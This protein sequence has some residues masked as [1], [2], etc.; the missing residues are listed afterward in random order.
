MEDVPNRRPPQRCLV[1][2]GGT[3]PAGW[4]MLYEP[5]AMRKAFRSGGAVFKDPDDE[6]DIDIY[7]TYWADINK[8]AK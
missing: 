7:D 1:I 6:R 8:W 4:E 3:R 2:Y 5:E